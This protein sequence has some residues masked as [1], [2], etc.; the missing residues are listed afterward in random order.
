MSP[1]PRSDSDGAGRWRLA[2]GAEVL[3]G[4]APR[5]VRFSVWAPRRE[6]LDLTLLS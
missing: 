6:R 1:R 2:R 4:S 5:A 3:A